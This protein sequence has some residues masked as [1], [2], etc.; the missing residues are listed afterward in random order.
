MFSIVDSTLSV[1]GSSTNTAMLRL[2][3]AQRGRYPGAGRWTF[4]LDAGKR[5][6]EAHV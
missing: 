6:D 4:V 5:G 1:C 3:Q 2:Y